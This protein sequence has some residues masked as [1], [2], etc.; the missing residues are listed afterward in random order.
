MTEAEYR[1]LAA[2]V[3]AKP[4]AKKTKRI[5]TCPS[6]ETEQQSVI[7]WA[8]LYQGT[9]PDLAMLWHIKSEGT[10]WSWRELHRSQALGVV[11][12]MPDLVMASPR[13]GYHGLWIELKARDGKVSPAQEKVLAALTERGYYVRVCFGAQAAIFTLLDYLRLPPTKLDTPTRVPV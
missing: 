8:R 4:A 13:G 2:H 6:E 3:S 11:P 10:T 1:T 5:R 7:A 9:Y 12:G